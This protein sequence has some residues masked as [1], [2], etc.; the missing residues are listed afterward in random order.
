MTE[1]TEAK[2]RNSVNRFESRLDTVED[3]IH[4]LENRL[5][6]N[7]HTELERRNNMYMYFYLLTI[8]IKLN[9]SP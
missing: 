6:E 1:N 5:I 9:M 4:E 3:N 2:I 8:S 7:I